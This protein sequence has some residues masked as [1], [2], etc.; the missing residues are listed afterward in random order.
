MNLGPLS[1]NE[2][3]QSRGGFN[4]REYSTG[5]NTQMGFSDYPMMGY[6]DNQMNNYDPFTGNNY[7]Y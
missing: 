3:S 4:N 6:E 1:G 2:R 5:F 7:G